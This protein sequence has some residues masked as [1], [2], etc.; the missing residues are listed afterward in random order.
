MRPPII[1]DEA[2]IIAALD[3]L[4]DALLAVSVAARTAAAL[5]DG[6]GDTYDAHLDAQLAI[7][8][9]FRLTN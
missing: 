3:A 1:R 7:R 9:V 6:A 2:A 5:D 8:R 4:D